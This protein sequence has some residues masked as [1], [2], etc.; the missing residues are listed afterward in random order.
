MDRGYGGELASLFDCVRGSRPFPISFENYV[1]TSLATF[2][3]EE[4]RRRGVPVAV[5]P[6]V[7]YN[8]VQEGGPGPV[9][10]LLIS[11]YYPP[12]VGS[13]AQKVSELAEY[14][15]DNGHQVTVV[16]GFP[17]HPAGVVYNGYRRKLYQREKV[18]GVRGDEN[19]FIDHSQT[20]EF[21]GKNEKSCV[22]H[23][24]VNIW[25]PGLGPA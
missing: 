2:C 1:L 4:S 3:I 11:Q 13:A 25:G 18:N 22:V 9:K 23:V 15:A 6:A 21:P 8:S 16:T 12:E 17:N 7:V 5:D 14:L 19:V 10:A 20:P 24:L